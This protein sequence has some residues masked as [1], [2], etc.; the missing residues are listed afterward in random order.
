MTIFKGGVVDVA[1]QIRDAARVAY[2]DLCP[3]LIPDEPD[4]DL[5]MTDD[6]ICGYMSFKHAVAYVL[7]PPKICEIGVGSGIA[8]LAFLKACPDA[9]YVGVDDCS[10]KGVESGAPLVDRA[11]VNLHGYNAFFVL[12]DSQ[13]LQTIPRGTFDLIHVDGS[14]LR[15]HARHD[16]R[17]AWSVLAP[18]GYL[19]IDDAR[20]T[21]VAAGV[22]D[23]MSALRPGSLDWAYFDDTLTGNILIHQGKARP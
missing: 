13:S 15:E 22:F 1:G 4:Y 10:M 20:D 12:D 23:A 6:Y 21:S 7:R 5:K 17:L 19:L 16:V 2:C 18:N 14:H 11:Q 9:E 8:A 3:M